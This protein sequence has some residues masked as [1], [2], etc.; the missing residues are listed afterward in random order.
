MSCPRYDRV[1]GFSGRRVVGRD[2]ARGWVS[3]VTVD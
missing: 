1:M 2:I 3:K